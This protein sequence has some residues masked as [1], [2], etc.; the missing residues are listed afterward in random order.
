MPVLSS[1]ESIYTTSDVAKNNHDYHL[2]DMI[3][4]EL[5]AERILDISRMTYHE[6]V[7]ISSLVVI[8]A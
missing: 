6:S 4:G 8:F 2:R 1:L 5:T 3:L 7:Y